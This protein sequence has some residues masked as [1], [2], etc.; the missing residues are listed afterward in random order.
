MLAVFIALGVY[1][2]LALFICMIPCLGRSIFYSVAVLA[3]F[4][5]T[6]CGVICA[7]FFLKDH[8]VDLMQFTHMAG[9]LLDHLKTLGEFVLRFNTTD[10]H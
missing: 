2:G 8:G 3:L 1:V 9:P 6:G 5:L 10:A 7:H 4:I